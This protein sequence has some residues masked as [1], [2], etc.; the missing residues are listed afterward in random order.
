[1]P[2]ISQAGVRLLLNDGEPIEPL[3]LDRASG[4]V[5]EEEICDVVR[6][7]ASDEELHGKIV[8]PLRIVPLVGSLGAKPTLRENVPDG[9]GDRLVTLPRPHRFGLDDGVEEE[10]PLVERLVRSGKPEWAASI[11]LEQLF[12]LR[13]F[14]RRL[15]GCFGFS[16]HIILVPSFLPA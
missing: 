8:D 7:R 12:Q 14:A 16:A 2:A 9:A 10:M 11:P 15:G 4:E 1:E 13:D 6:E 5:I 3:I